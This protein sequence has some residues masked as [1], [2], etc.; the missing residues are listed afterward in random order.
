[1]TTWVLDTNTVMALWLFGD[2]RLAPLWQWLQGSDVRLATRAD[3]LE[4]WRRVLAYHQ[5]AVPAGR[6]AALLA[7]YAQRCDIVVPALPPEVRLPACRD[8]DDQ[9]FLEIARDARASCL[10]TR[11]KVLLKLARHRLIRPLYRILTPEAAQH[12]M[13]LTRQATDAAP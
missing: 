1:M 11:D 4:E 7:C 12:D 9:K 5:F 13:L 6:Q 8:P 3:A 2:P 10:I